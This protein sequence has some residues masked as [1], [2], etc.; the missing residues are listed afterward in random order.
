[1][2]GKQ[3]SQ[4]LDVKTPLLVEWVRFCLLDC[5]CTRFLIHHCQDG[6]HLEFLKG[7]VMWGGR[8]T[9]WHSLKRLF[10]IKRMKLLINNSFNDLCQKCLTGLG[11]YLL[12]M[13]PDQ[14][15]LNKVWITVVFKDPGKCSE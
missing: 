4:T 11:S 3:I 14:V 8:N 5:Y 6:C 1:M 12:L 10:W 2:T 9:N 15:S 13:H 7:Q